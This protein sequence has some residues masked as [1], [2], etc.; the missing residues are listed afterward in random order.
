MKWAATAGSY[1]ITASRSNRAN[2]GYSK[3]TVGQNGCQLFTR[4]VSAALHGNAGNPTG[5]R[6]YRLNNVFRQI[7]AAAND[8]CFV[9]NPL[10]VTSIT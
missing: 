3:M 5:M 10:H 2:G 4:F 9:R 8:P 6:A 7:P 1:Y